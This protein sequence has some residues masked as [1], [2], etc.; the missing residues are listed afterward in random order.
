MVVQSRIGERLSLSL[1][2]WS[3]FGDAIAYHN[4]NTV[5]VFGG[6]PGE[7]VVA[8]VVKERGTYIAARVVE[9]IRPSP[10]R[11][12]SPCRY[13]GECTGC[14]WQHVDYEKQ[15]RMKTQTV[16]DALVDVGDF[17]DPPVSPCLGAPEQYGY[18]N[19]A[20]FTARRDGSL[21]FVNRDTRRFVKVQECLLMHPWINDALGSLQDRCGETTQLSIRYGTNTGDFLIQPTLKSSEVPLR[22]GQKH[23]T[24]SIEGRRFRIAASS[25][26][27]VNT[28]QAERLVALVREGLRLTGDQIL[29][30]A[31][32][33][34]GTFAALL[35]PHVKKVIAIEEAAS[36][37]D[38]AAVH[39]ADQENVEFILGK[40]EEV[41]TQI[42]DSPDAIILDP[43]R[44]GC[45]PKA[46]EAVLKLS[47]ERIVYVSCDPPALARDLKVLCQ[48]QYRI[49]E[50]HP[51]DMFP[52]TRH[53]ECVAVLSLVRDTG[54]TGLN[55]KPEGTVDLVLA[56]TSPRRRELMSRLG[57]SYRAVP[58]KSSELAQ[59]NE[60]PEEMSERLALLKARSI[61]SNTSAS[62]VIGAD[63]VVVLD[64][65]VLGKPKDE[66]DARGMLRDLRGREHR[67]VTGVAVIDG[68]RNREYVARK[69]TSVQMRDYS[70]HE[71][72]AYV[73]SGRA[74]DKAGSYGIQ[75]V[76]FNPVADLDSCYT[77]V[78]GLPLC[79]L[80][81]MLNRVGV[82]TTHVKVPNECSQCPLKEEPRQ[83]NAER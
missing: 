55:G 46:L 43:P 52:Q 38:D 14:Q 70:D 72:E 39:T 10:H 66:D 51:I 12:T 65:V 82:D 31:Y 40:T 68:S 4:G 57:I 21:G 44:V 7:E 36:A 69:V 20:R 47:P 78:V 28:N 73:T 77:N 6:I 53:V 75:D 80:A 32:A 71:I 74:A 60:T 15:L 79:T 45:Q 19:H 37:V 1:E 67:V 11:V 30:D 50:V 41:L 25:F 3:K 48:D 27:Q 18:R 9:V 33:G 59:G 35:D 8:E 34:V 62:L 56:S 49:E 54:N 58:P 22:S 61:S 5:N 24:E 2:G 42:N 23:Y 63:T 81:D 76:D 16:I 64:G 83:L 17:V 26:F 29:V 13:F